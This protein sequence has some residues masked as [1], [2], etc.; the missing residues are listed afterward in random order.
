[1]GG[2]QGW[3]HEGRMSPGHSSVRGWCQKQCRAGAG[4]FEKE[5]LFFLNFSVCFT[6]S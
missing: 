5:F 1:M 4:S 6:K 3:G 2:Q